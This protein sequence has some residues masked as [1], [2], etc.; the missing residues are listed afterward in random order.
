M[1]VGDIYKLQLE[2]ITSSADALARIDGKP[3]FIEG[4]APFETIHCRITEEHKT[5]NRAELLEIIEPS[6]ARIEPK[7]AFYG[8]CG[9]CNLQHIDY[10]TQLD[11]KKKILKD[12]FLRIGGFDPPQIEVIPSTPWEYRNRMQFHC[13]RQKAKADEIGFGLKEKT[14]VNIITITEC[15]VAVRGIN[16]FLKGKNITLP[17][18]KDRFTV[19]SKDDL[20]M[21]EGDIQRAKITLLDKEIIVESGVFFQSNCTMLEKLILELQKITDTHNKID[22]ALPMADLYCGVGTFAMFLAEKFPYVILAEENKTAVSIAH[23]NLKGIKHEIFA[24][25]DTDWQKNLLNKKEKGS[26]SF[27]VLDPPRSGLNFKLALSLAQND[28]PV[29]AYVSCDP[30][31]LARDSKVLINGGYNLE[32]LTL[33]DFYPQTTHI[34]SLAVFKR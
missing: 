33:F 28:I 13:L 30:I 20:L 1:A 19:F 32:K 10:Q 9:G 21:S 18:D 34:E 3:V 6:P 23:E 27:A 4:G 7:C 26:F 14:G 2:S 17:P 25:R 12:S 5:W 11:I 16:K 29:L 22:K 24:L 31:S 15:P 8:K